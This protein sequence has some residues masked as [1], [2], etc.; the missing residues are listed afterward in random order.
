MGVPVQA[1]LVL[2]SVS[3]VLTAIVAGFFF[4]AAR[5]TRATAHLLFGIGLL[6][7]ALSFTT[8]T[9][10]QFDLGR[11]PSVFDHLRIVGQLG[12]ALVILFSYLSARTHGDPRTFHVLGMSVVAILGAYVVLFLF[13]LPF[14]T[15]PDVE[16]LLAY[17]HA[18]MAIVW[19][20]SALLSG[21]QWMKAPAWDRVL[22]PTAFVLFGV[23]KYTWFIIDLAG[24]NDVVLLVYVWR[25]S[26]IALLLVAMLLPADV[27]KEATPTAAA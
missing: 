25:F 1:Y 26:A 24:T 2:D 27:H 21:R 19:T 14:G 6:V 10:S 18:A 3:A 9:A 15:F 22:V 8:V 16:G 13:I 23:S 11:A 20:L 7:V 4:V 5:R 17:G 12:G